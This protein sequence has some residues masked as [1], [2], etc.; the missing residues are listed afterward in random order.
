MVRAAHVLAIV[1]LCAAG[2][3]VAQAQSA[4]EVAAARRLYEQGVEHANAGRW[5]E[6]R[7]A[8]AQSLDLA[9][10]PPTLLNLAGALV[11]TG[12]LV[13][14][15]EAYR[16]YLRIA[17]DG[18]HRQQAEAQLSEL[19]GR[20]PRVTLRVQ[21][22]ADRD[23]LRIDGD[24]TA[25]AIVGVEVPFDPGHHV[26]DVTRA[27]ARVATTELDVT[28]G[29]RRE[30]TLRVVGAAVGDEGPAERVDLIIDDPGDP[31]EEERSEGGGVFSSP[32]FWVV[33]GAIVIGA[34]VATTVVLMSG[35]SGPDAFTGNVG[36]G[37]LGVP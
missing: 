32:V 29:S 7:E 21:G 36:V 30:V 20:L 25:H 34:A 12:H 27:G 8:F 11:Q 5:E 14:G 31:I 24:I 9:E 13:E 1:V 22:L 17:P 35:G 33:V 15:A 16:R 28:E 10:R 23:E 4:R 37:R 6:A 18:R 19:D 2:V 26:I 3:S